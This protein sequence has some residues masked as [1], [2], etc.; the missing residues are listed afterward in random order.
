MD[1]P[2]LIVNWK[3]KKGSNFKPRAPIYLKGG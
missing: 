3:R 2:K 1:I